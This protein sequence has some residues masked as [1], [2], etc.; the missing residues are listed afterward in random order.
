MCDAESESDCVLCVFKPCARIPWFWGL[1]NNNL[2]KLLQLPQAL[3]G[4]LPGSRAREQARKERTVTCADVTAWSETANTVTGLLQQSP[5][6]LQL[7]IRASPVW[8]AHAMVPPPS[9]TLQR[10]LNDIQALC[11][12]TRADRGVTLGMQD[13]LL[14]RVV[15]GQGLL[16]GQNEEPPPD[17]T[18]FVTDDEPKG[19][20]ASR[21]F[22]RMRR[23]VV[24]RWR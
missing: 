3:T 20:L 18:L 22:R 17:Q 21:E 23:G 6:V 8:V 5:R 14:A 19:E 16:R 15:T 1:N 12:R 24:G 7:T 2:V 10:S 13:V 9:R 11:A 4:L